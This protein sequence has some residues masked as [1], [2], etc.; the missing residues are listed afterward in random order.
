MPSYA[1]VVKE[2]ANSEMSW[3]AIPADQGQS[4]GLAGGL[5]LFTAEGAAYGLIPAG[6]ASS[7]QSISLSPNGRILIVDPGRAPNRDLSFYSYPDLHSLGSLAVFQRGEEPPLLWTDKGQA[8]FTSI[9]VESRQ[10]PCD[11]APCGP[12]SVK[13]FNPDEGKITTILAGDPTCDYTAVSVAGG[14][15]TATKLCLAAA[16]SWRFYPEGQ[17]GVKVTARLPE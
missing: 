15:L 5:Y 16:T 11:Y 10:R 2:V 4:L 6:A 7:S 14:E 1:V 3:A 13:F 12:T 8:L 9:E 17:T